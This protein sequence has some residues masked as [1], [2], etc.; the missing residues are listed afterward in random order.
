MTVARPKFPGSRFSGTGAAR[1]KRV[2]HAKICGMLSEAKYV[3]A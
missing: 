2:V 1:L 3:T